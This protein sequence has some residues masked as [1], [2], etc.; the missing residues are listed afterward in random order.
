MFSAGMNMADM[1][2]EV[3][4]REEDMKQRALENERRAIDDARRSVDEKAQQL[5]A[6][7]HQSALIGGFTMVALVE[8]PI[9]SNLNSAQL[10][11]FGGTASSVIGLMLLAMLNATFMLVAILKYDCVNRDVKFSDFWRKRCESD[12][13]LALRCFS[14]GVPLFMTVLAQVGWII[15]WDHEQATIYASTL[16]SLVAFITIVFWFAH[17]NRKWGGFLLST[18]AKLYNPNI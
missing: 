1:A 15:F 4:C 11:I 13:K 9:P 7:A 12:W 3:K 5:K 10:I 8:M 16:V 6:V 17:T 18:D 14:Y 2:W